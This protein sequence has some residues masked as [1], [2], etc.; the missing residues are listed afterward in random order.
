LR[1]ITEKKGQLSV[2]LSE[3]LALE[4]T[5]WLVLDAILKSG[6]M[7]FTKKVPTK[8]KKNNTNGEICRLV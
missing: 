7:M 3:N 5:P 4:K 6:K 1:T 2:R 8:R